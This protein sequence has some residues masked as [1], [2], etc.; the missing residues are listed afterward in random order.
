MSLRRVLV[1]SVAAVG[2]TV[3]LAAGV[4]F[5]CIT[6]SAV[7]LSTATGK[8]GDVVTINGTNWRMPQG[9]T[10]NGIEV[11][12]KAPNGPLLAT[13]VPDANGTFKTDFTIPDG[14]PGYYVVAAVMK[15]AQGLDV[16]GTPGRAIFEVQGLPAPPVTNAPARPF[17]ENSG[18]SGSSFPIVLVV[19]LGVV[20]LALFAGG[21]VAV[22]RSR[23]AKAPA[24]AAIRSD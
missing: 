17:T 8:V 6:P 19:G 5:A 3:T 15:D 13:A 12:W 23:R 7:N 18:S 14:P 1:G 16:E 22:S 11:H 4:A 2:A 9:S 10:T 21:F 24:S 20:G